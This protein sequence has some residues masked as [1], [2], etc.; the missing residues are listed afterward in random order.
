LVERDKA[1]VFGL[2]K[3]CPDFKAIRVYH[4]NLSICFFNSVFICYFQEFNI[5]G[6]YTSVNVECLGSV[7]V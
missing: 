4:D 6:S 7:L 1:M 5:V 3:N 2:L